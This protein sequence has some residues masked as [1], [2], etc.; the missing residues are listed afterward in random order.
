MNMSFVQEEIERLE[1]K[2]IISEKATRPYIAN[3]LTVAYKRKG[4][5]RLV[6]DCRH[7]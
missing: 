6:F 4:K 3:P 2:E 7:K 1:K 5:A